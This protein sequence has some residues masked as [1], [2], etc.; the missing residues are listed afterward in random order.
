[1]RTG[2][3]FGIAEGTV[4]TALSRM[5]TG[6]ELVAER[7]GY[8]LA[9]HLVERQHRQDTS[10]R[11]EVREWDGTWEL[12]SI[13]D[14]EARPATDRATLRRAL[15]TLRL[16]E[17]REGLWGRPDNL[18]PARSPDAS[19]VVD[20]WCARW[21]GAVP[22][23][24]PDLVALWDLD[25]WAADAR[26]LRHDMATLVNALEADD[27]KALAEGFVCSAGVLRLL[28][29]DPLLP[30][31]LLPPSWPGTGLRRDYDR[32]DTAYRGA[33]RTWFRAG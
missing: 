27:A 11:A 15:G 29:H 2:A 21:T 33:L 23:A 3:L 25:G 30:P 26:Q 24:M 1:V 14:D 18:D 7:N 19:V 6:G 5:T 10:R 20:K 13:A 28:Q 31:A 32:F 17:L 12:A 22:D 4:R 16:A 8:R 9:G